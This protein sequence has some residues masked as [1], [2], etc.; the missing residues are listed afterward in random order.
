M[1]CLDLPLLVGTHLQAAAA[2]SRRT[3]KTCEEGGTAVRACMQ[4]SKAPPCLLHSG[5]FSV[6]SADREHCPL[7]AVS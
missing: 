6:T 4:S 5:V 1:P 3:G 7:L 2:H